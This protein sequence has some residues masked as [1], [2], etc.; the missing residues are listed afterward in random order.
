LAK[1]RS[2]RRS[3]DP[4][5]LDWLLLPYDAAV[6]AWGALRAALKR[7]PRSRWAL[8]LFVLALAVRLM[9]P[10]WYSTRTFHP[11][12]RW[13]FDKTAELHLWAEPGKTDGAGMQYGSLPLYAVSVIKDLCHGLFNAGEYHAAQVGGRA[14]TGCIDA[15]TV[16]GTYLLAVQLLGT[17]WALFAALLVACAPLHIQLSHFFTVDPWLACF[18]TLTLAACV[19]LAAKPSLALSAGVGVLFAAGLASK[20]SGLPLLAPITLAHLW[21]ALAPGLAAK[22]RKVK[23]F[24][25]GKGLGV[26]AGATLLGFFVFMPW[27]FLDFHKFVANQTAQQDILVKG[28]PGGVPFVRQYWDTGIGF[29]LRNIALF[30]L[31]LPAGLLA[32]L[33]VPAIALLGI[34]GALKAWQPAAPKPRARKPLLPAPATPA[35]LWQAALAPALLLGWCLP[36]YAIVG[37]SFAKFARYMLPILPT[38]SVLLALGLAALAQRWAKPVRILA[39]TVAVFSLGHGFGYALTYFQPHPWIESSRWAFEHIPATVEDPAAPGGRRATR[40]MNEDWGDDLPVD[41]EGASNLRY[42]QLKGRSDQVNIVEWDSQNK[43]QRL[44]TTLSQADVLFLADPRAYGTY[45]RLPTRFPLT[46][47]YYDLLFSDPGKLGFEL[48][49]ERAN[50]IKVFGLIPLPDDRTPRVP[51]ALWAD[52]SFTLYDRPHAFVFRRV[53]P[54]TPEEIQQVLLD[55]IK[56]LG[57]SLEWMHGVGPE[58]L[59]RQAGGASAGDAAPSAESETALNPNYGQDRGGLVPLVNPVLSWWILV[60]LMGF[61]A[62]PLALRVFSAWPAGGYALSRALGVLLFGWLAYNLAW[63]KLLPF[64]QAWLWALLALLTLAVGTG[65]RRQT[66]AVKAWFQANRAEVLF[67]EAVFG[68]AFLYF[69]LVRAFNPNIHDITGQGYFGGGEPLGMTYLSAVSRC[70]T[71]PAYD[72]WLALHNSSYYYFGYVLAA[73]LTKLSGFPASVTYNLSLALFF[74][75]S[76]VTAYGLLRVFSAKRWVALGGAAMVALAGSLWSIAYLAIQMNR[77]MGPFSALFSHGFI[78]DPTRFPEL[79]QGHIF[80]FPYFSYLYSDLHP[81]NMVVAFSLVLLA[82]LA[83]P[84][85]SR[86][87]GWRAAG[88]TPVLAA[89]WLVLVALFLDVQYAINTWSWPVFL[90]L[91]AAT[92]LIAP[93]A[94]KGLR[95]WDGVKAASIGAAALL[96]AALGGRLLMSGFRHYYLQNGGN[97]VGHVLPSEWQMSSYIPL[98]F[99]LPGFAALAVLAGRRVRA[100]SDGLFKPLGADKLGRKDWFDQ[101]LTLIERLFERRL[102]T[103]LGAGA[104]KLLILGLLAVSLLKF[105]NQGVWALA[106]GLGF[107]CLAAF[108]AGGHRSGTESFL[109]VLGGFTCFLVAGSEFYFVADRMNTIFKF[110]FNGWILMGVVFGAGLAQAF[111]DAAPAKAAKPPK[112]KGRGRRVRLPLDKALPWLVGAGLALLGFAAAFLDARLMNTGGRFI[113]SFLAFAVLLLALFGLAFVYGDRAWFRGVQRGVWGGLLGLGLL[114]PFGATIARLQETG[115]NADFKSPHLDGLAF[116]GAREQRGGFDAKDYDKD[117]YALIQWLNQNARVTETVL[118]APGIEMYKGYDRFAIYTG[119]PTLLGWDYQVGQQLGER[120]GNILNERKQ[121]ASIIY[122][123]TVEQA[124]PLL[125]KYHVRWIAVG[126]IERRQFAGAGLDKFASMATEVARSGSSVLY[127]F[128]WDQP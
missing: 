64:T 98:A 9:R 103:A 69:V 25:A 11:D 83:V 79:V 97:R 34:R 113:L 91:T 18:A 1:R 76:L 122:S 52:E 104:L 124:K 111:G 66:G 77:G 38:L 126:D 44:S 100:Y 43:L 23:F 62:L 70:V 47:A 8:L 67:T 10:D 7:D 26:A 21:S 54:H 114:Y 117:D 2:S 73:A 40:V 57:G 118:E 45:L 24:E 27:A 49:Y 14:L 120:T 86:Q 29:H 37:S 123:G 84:F 107:T 87:A 15:L 78:W 89:V 31:G 53:A 4:L 51:R 95:L 3:S 125:Q 61:L 65:L 127:R 28:S 81:H 92:F 88:G 108:A 22:E 101:A 30:Y 90:C 39:W 41:V 19:R 33:A 56:E 72:P 128:E 82:L 93:W 116:M 35:S 112:A 48:A 55:R 12:E 85:V 80:E 74:S 96:A 68:G 60:S 71:F 115:L 46:H 110:W 121:D 102:G 32:L 6:A 59:E 106:L 109:W 36:Y 42:E 99:F 17:G 75:L 13:L 94:G 119:L 58:D 105:G 63:L 50:P 5:D 20:S 16:V